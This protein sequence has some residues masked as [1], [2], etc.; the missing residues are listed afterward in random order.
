MKDSNTPIRITL[1]LLKEMK[2]HLGLLALEKKSRSMPVQTLLKK[3]LMVSLTLSI[4][5]LEQHIGMDSILREDGKEFMPRTCSKLTPQ[6]L[7][8][9]NEVLHSTLSNQKDGLHPTS[10]I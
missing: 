6:K 7:Q 5:L 9:L 1:A 4:S 10:R 2:R 3:N 8:I